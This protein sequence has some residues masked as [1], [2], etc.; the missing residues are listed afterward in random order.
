VGF[1]AELAGL[2][3]SLFYAI[4]VLSVIIVNTIIVGMFMVCGH[5][6]LVVACLA[7]GACVCRISRARLPDTARTM[8]L[9]DSG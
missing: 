1:L 9:Y 4:I 6:L 8:R 2:P 5:M 7:A 3:N